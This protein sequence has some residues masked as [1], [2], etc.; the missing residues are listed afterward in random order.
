MMDKFKA[1]NKML[2]LQLNFV[3]EVY[4]TDLVPLSLEKYL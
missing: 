3:S 1:D 4:L 2:S